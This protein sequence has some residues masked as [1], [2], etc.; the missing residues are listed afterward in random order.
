MQGFLSSPV[1]DD[2]LLPN[3]DLRK[4][5]DQSQITRS[6]SRG[7]DAILSFPRKRESK[8]LNRE[9]PRK[10][11]VIRRLRRFHRF[12]QAPP[13]GKTFPALTCIARFGYTGSQLGYMEK[14]VEEPKWN[15]RAVERAVPSMRSRIS[16]SMGSGFFCGGRSIFCPSRS[17]P[18]SARP[19]SRRSRT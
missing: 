1:N 2:K 8:F 17:S 11:K 3:L 4:F 15:H 13:A 18:G 6:K 19:K 12:T 7:A 16:R 9:P 10:R 5:N 14:L